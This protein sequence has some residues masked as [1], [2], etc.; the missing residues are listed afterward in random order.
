MGRS[1]VAPSDLPTISGSVALLRR[2]G[3]RATVLGVAM[4][5]SL[6]ALV[7]PALAHAIEVWMSD[8]E[9]TYG[10]LIPPIAL[11][12][13]WLRRE[14]L[15]RSI[16]PGRASGLAIVLAAIVL[17]LV[18]RRVGI[19]ALA[20]VAVSP[21]LV[22]V[23][24]YLWGWRAARIVAFPAAFLMF[25]LGLYRGLLNSV[26]FSLQEATAAGAA[27]A[28][29][30]IGLSVV[31]DGLVLHSASGSPAYAFVVA[32]ACSG[33]SSLLSL[34]S[35]AALWM[36]AT[37]GSIPARA[38]VFGAVLPLVVIANTVRVTLVLLV[39][40][41]FGE[42]AALGFFHGASSLVLFGLALLGLL[43]VSRIA[44]CK[45]PAIA[46]SS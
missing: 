29:P 24:A 37:H 8:E 34:L 45:L 16:G 14:A 5:V 7:V 21:L 40:A 19:H 30:V 36:Y 2:N 1:S 23:A 33:M 44:G 46:T 15:K 25:G 10:F 26:G 32:Q 27:W 43:L 38:A 17:T 39:G 9:F 11:A 31:R 35:L 42:E 3:R 22:G 18:S 41:S 13:L 12:I 20:G 6:L 28:G 4:V